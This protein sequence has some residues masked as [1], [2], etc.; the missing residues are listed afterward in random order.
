MSTVFHEYDCNISDGLYDVEE[1]AFSARQIHPIILTS[2]FWLSKFIIVAITA[3][4][5]HISH[6]I[7]YIALSG[8]T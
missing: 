4:A 6:F 1:I 3:A 7:S 8:F 2:I 5:Q